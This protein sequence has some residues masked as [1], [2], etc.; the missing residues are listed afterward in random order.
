MF[1]LG[2][3][4][5]DVFSHI[6]KYISLKDVGSPLCKIAYRVILAEKNRRIEMDIENSIKYEDQCVL[7]THR[8]ELLEKIE[9]AMK[10]KCTIKFISELYRKIYINNISSNVIRMFINEVIVLCFKYNRMDII[11]FLDTPIPKQLY[12]RTAYYIGYNGINNKSVI[13]NMLNI[14]HHIH[15][16]CV[17]HGLI[18]GGYNNLLYYPTETDIHMFVYW[19]GM[20]NNT[21]MID[22][23]SKKYNINDALNAQFFR[24]VIDSGNELAF[25]QHIKMI[26]LI[27][28]DN[29]ILLLSKNKFIIKT[30]ANHMNIIPPIP[31]LVEY[32]MI[33][34]IEEHIQKLS[35]TEILVESA[36]LGNLT[37]IKKYLVDNMKTTIVLNACANGHLH[38]I[39]YMNENHSNNILKTF[40]SIIYMSRNIKLIE[41]INKQY[42]LFSSITD[43]IQTK[44]I[45]KAAKDGDVKF[46]DYMISNGI[47]HKSRFSGVLS[48]GY[49]SNIEIILTLI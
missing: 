11:K 43:E 33:D 18:I 49:N 40:A 27:N 15:I 9:I 30:I 41:Y 48:A 31:K 19:C 22:T 3:I 46:I 6:L 45:R 7:V 35:I 34:Y 23:I 32:D 16:Q 26:H 38:I 36:K 29:Y 42:N 14:S 13:R 4:S 8:I 25:R 2:N 28:K 39:K 12:F 17:Q 1:N 44:T 10:N 5:K 24:G 21:K 37:L 47:T 20:S